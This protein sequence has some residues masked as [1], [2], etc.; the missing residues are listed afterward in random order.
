MI[1][2]SCTSM[3]PWCIQELRKGSRQDQA[4]IPNINAWHRLRPSCP[5]TGSEWAD[6]SIVQQSLGKVVFTTIST[7]LLNHC[8]Y[9]A[10]VLW[11]KRKL[12]Q[13][14]ATQAMARPAMAGL[15]MPS[16]WGRE[17]RCHPLLEEGLPSARWTED[18]SMGT[19]HWIAPLCHRH[20]MCVPGMMQYI[21][22]NYII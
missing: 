18:S 7:I 1:S 8:S 5:V 6:F 9:Q 13:F 10:R 16:S 12:L 11:R 2:I 19:F 21:S 17:T 3:A 15:W 22:Y 20:A 14:L 4:W